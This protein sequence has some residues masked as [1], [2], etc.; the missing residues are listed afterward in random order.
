MSVF[1][2]HNLSPLLYFS[3]LDLSPRKLPVINPIHLVPP[4]DRDRAFDALLFLYFFLTALPRSR[5]HPPFFPFP[6]FEDSKGRKKQMTNK[7]HVR[8]E[9]NYGD[10]TEDTRR[11]RNHDH[12]QSEKMG[13]R[14][15]GCASADVP[16]PPLLRNLSIFLNRAPI[17]RIQCK[18]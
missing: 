11:C 18:Y 13:S 7:Q 6:P 8:V 4:L 5:R 14:E 1:T 3:P 16:P 9:S 10:I 2:F 12:N 15:S 17:L